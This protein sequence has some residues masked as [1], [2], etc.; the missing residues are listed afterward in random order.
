MSMLNRRFPIHRKDFVRAGEAS[1]QVKKVLKSLDIPQPFVRRISICAYEGE[2]NVVMHGGEGEMSLE[3]DPRRIVLEIRDTGPG[4]E[5]IDLAM[6]EGFSTA[7]DEFREL[8][9]G[10]GMGLPNMKKNTDE[11]EIESPEGAGVRVRMTFFP[12]LPGRKDR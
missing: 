4:I 5:D 6:R 10:A 11:F 1:M 9:F 3:I 7:S 2:M 12:D 8:G